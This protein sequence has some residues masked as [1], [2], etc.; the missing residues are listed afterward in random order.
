MAGARTRAA[1]PSLQRKAEI[2]QTHSHLTLAPADLLITRGGAAACSPRQFRRTDETVASGPTALPPRSAFRRRRQPRRSKLRGAE[3]RQ[4]SPGGTSWARLF[5]ASVPTPPAQH[6]RARETCFNHSHS[7]FTSPLCRDHTQ[8]CTLSSSEPPSTP[9]SLPLH[10]VLSAEVAAAAARKEAALGT[11]SVRSVRD[12]LD[13]ARDGDRIIFEN[14]PH[15]VG[16]DAVVVDKRVLIQ[17]A[18][19]MPHP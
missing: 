8:L 13:K 5:W 14:G 11:L 16:G 12:A 1:L 6:R 7:P 9:T 15:N 17:C 10:Q 3:P 18:P 4:L 19:L 2:I